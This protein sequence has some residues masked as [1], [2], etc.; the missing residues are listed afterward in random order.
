MTHKI[1]GTNDGSVFNSTGEKYDD[2]TVLV[3][4]SKEQRV[5]EPSLFDFLRHPDTTLAEAP[6]TTLLADGQME[7]TL[8]FRIPVHVVK[9]MQ[10]AF[11][12]LF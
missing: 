10:K 7:A 11:P 12:S 4:K 2:V 3:E 1:S 8:T 6:C 5:S 9:E